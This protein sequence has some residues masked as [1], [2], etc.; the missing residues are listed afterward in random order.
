[1]ILIMLLATFVLSALTG[2][3]LRGRI[4]YLYPAAVSALFVPSV[5]IYYNE[6]ALIHVLWYLVAS[7]AGVL[8]GSF[9]R[10]TAVRNKKIS[11]E[12]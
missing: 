7:F 12:K 10:W 9:I 3:A 11:D 5:F 2:A 1:M 8:L 6:S 4:K